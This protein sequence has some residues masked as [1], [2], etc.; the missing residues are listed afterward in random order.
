MKGLL[1]LGN[2]CYFNSALQCL[3]Q[4]PHLSNYFIKNEYSGDCEFTKEYQK[5]VRD[6]WRKTNI[7]P[8]TAK[9][10]RLFRTRFSQF[11][12]LYPHDAQEAFICMIDILEPFT[13]PIINFKMVQE[14]VCP[15]GKTTSEVE[16]TVLTLGPTPSRNIED[17]L[18]KSIDWVTIE[19]YQDNNGKV[20]NVAATRTVFATFP[21][22]LVLSMTC[23]MNLIV[24][25]KILEGAYT[26]IAS[27]I[28]IGTNRGGHY[29]ALTKHKGTW[30]LK[31]D[32]NVSTKSEFIQDA[33]HY[34]LV[35]RKETP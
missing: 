8:D 22:I 14:T 5:I 28:H 19:N 1:N 9:I 11:E 18:K 7:V 31:D 10:L 12:A 30:Y 33:G 6:M 21:Q 34:L 4:I 35:F 24:P 25:E 23:K 2:T 29:V 32:M 15:S 20:W 3:L 26:L 17:S 13:K 16:S 27:C